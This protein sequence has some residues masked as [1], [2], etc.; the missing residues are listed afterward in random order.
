MGKNPGSLFHITDYQQFEV[1]KNSN[2]GSFKLMRILT[3]AIH[4]GINI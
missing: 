3:K 4:S 2:W 1:M